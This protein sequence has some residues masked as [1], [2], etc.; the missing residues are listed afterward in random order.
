MRVEVLIFMKCSK[1]KIRKL[2]IHIT[3]LAKLLVVDQS[4]Q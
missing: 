3:A 1:N 4:E 2:L